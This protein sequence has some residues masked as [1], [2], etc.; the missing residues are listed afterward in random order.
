MTE[1]TVVFLVE[2]VV[3][4]ALDVLDA[5]FEMHHASLHVLQAAFDSLNSHR[6]MKDSGRAA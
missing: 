6:V 5:L 4:A 2:M 3:N 1:L